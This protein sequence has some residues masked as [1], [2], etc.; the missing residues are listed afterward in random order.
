MTNEQARSATVDFLVRL[1][2]VDQRQ[3]TGRDVL[4]LYTII[5]NPGIMGVEVANKLGLGNR[6][7]VS[8]NIHRLCRGSYIEDRREKARKAN[9]AILHVLP[10][11]L[12][13]WDEIKP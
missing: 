9:P 3:L 12:E 13:F 11:G 4:V 10:A 1:R 6:S 8:S 7:N 5:S 2:K